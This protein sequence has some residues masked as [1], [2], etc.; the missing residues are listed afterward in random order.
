MG[1]VSQFSRKAQAYERLDKTVTDRYEV[2]KR[3][4]RGCY[5]IVFDAV[6]HSEEIKSPYA[7]KKIMHAFKNATDAQRAYREVMYLKA[8]SDHENIITL[9]EVLCASNDMHLYLVFE[10]MDGSLAVALRTKALQPIHKDLICY[11]L[12]RALKWVHSANVVHRDVTPANILLTKLCHVKL[13]DFGWA[14][15][16]PIVDEHHPMTDYAGTRWYRAPE[17]IFGARHYTAAVDMWAL[18][19][20]TGEVY[21]NGPLI[22]GS[23]NI[24]MIEKMIELTGKPIPADV[25][26]LDCPNAELAMEP[27]PPGPPHKSVEAMYPNEAQD[28]H[29]F[30]QLLIQW[31]PVKRLTATEA[32]THPFLGAHHNPD[33]EPAIGRHVTLELNDSEQ[34]SL[35]WYRDQIYA[36]AIGIGKAKL[37]V[38]MHRRRALEDLY[39]TLG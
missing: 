2:G 6:R 24:D 31:N 12:T 21:G 27:I 38:E 10:R 18:G 3:I 25:A 1:N 28:M 26:A 30:V 5:G 13:A 15:D 32:L 29:D 14:R 9:K 17:V 20:I 37:K 19:C 16:L 22:G 11:Q 7:V 23:S 33:D 4:G 8:L 35:N 39:E 36:D 34:V